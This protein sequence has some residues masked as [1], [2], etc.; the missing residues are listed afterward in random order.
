MTGEWKHKLSL[1]KS[2]QTSSL[3]SQGEPVNPRMSNVTLAELAF[4][5]FVY[6][7]MTAYD[8]SLARFW[9]ATNGNPDPTSATHRSEL[10]K[11]LNQWGCRQFSVEYH[12]VAS[13]SILAWYKEVGTNL[14]RWGKHLW[15]LDQNDF[16]AAGS[17][18]AVLSR[19]TASYRR[20]GVRT[21]LI[22]VGPTGAAKILFALRPHAFVPWDGRIR[23]SLGYDG[24]PAA[25]VAYLC[26]VKSVLEAIERAC[27]DRGF[28]L[29]DLP[30][31]LGSPTSTVPQLIDEYLWV[32]VTQ[33]CQPPSRDVF[34]RWAEWSP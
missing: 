5:T 20:R 18:Y 29:A 34:H 22:S 4:A 8:E 17:V 33:G 6:R 2:N 19:K 1:V 25:Y 30:R 21:L 16:A 12:R 27:H 26:E 31:Q 14:V 7:C 23:E 9:Q 3:L 15:E 13:E 11:W 24:R 32:T 10:I 28:E